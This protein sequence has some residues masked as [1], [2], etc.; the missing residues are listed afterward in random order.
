MWGWA[1]TFAAVFALD[2]VYARYTVAVTDGRKI[3]ASGYAGAVIALSGFAAIN[4]VSDHWL[5]VPAIAG[6]V[7]GTLVGMLKLHVS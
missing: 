7:A 5:L 3:A 2:V 4:Y 1:L 6:A